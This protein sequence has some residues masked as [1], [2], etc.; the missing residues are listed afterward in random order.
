VIRL[1]APSGLHAG[2][3]GYPSRFAITPEQP[4]RVYVLTRRPGH[5]FAQACVAASLKKLEAD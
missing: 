5:L 2:F 4:A 1:P 3:A